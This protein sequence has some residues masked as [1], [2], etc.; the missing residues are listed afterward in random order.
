MTH[1]NIPAAYNY[2]DKHI[3]RQERFKLLEEYNLSIAGSIPN[4][5]WELFGAILTGDKGRRGYGADLSLH[6]IKSAVLRN[7][8]EY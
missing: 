2:Y 4:I 5:D 6:E 7:S 8:F 1:F 3:N